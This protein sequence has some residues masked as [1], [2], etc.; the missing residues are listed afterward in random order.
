MLFCEYFK[1]PPEV[2][3]TRRRQFEG[4]GEESADGRQKSVGG[5]IIKPVHPGWILMMG[6]GTD[7]LS[8][9]CN[10]V[11]KIDFFLD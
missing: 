4:G 11:K 6:E 2:I 7:K 3:H 8:A 1:N 10:D 9:V 5:G